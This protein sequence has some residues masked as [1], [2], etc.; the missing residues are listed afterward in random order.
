M[1]ISITMPLDFGVPWMP[2]IAL[3][4]KGVKYIEY[5]KW[6]HVLSSNVVK[7]I[8]LLGKERKKGEEKNIEDHS[9]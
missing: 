8:S 7:T 3:H 5:E 6:E 2:G 9:L 4:K 1:M